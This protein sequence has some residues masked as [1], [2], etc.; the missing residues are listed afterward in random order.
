MPHVVRRTDI[1]HAAMLYRR[2]FSTRG[3]SSLT[4]WSRGKVIRLLRLAG[5]EMRGPGPVKR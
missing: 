3:I 5:V 4:G 2:G 1:E